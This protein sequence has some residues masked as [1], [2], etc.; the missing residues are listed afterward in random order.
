MAIY[1][2]GDLQGCFDE[3]RR[4]LDAIGFD[5]PGDTLWLTGDL[6]NRGPKS[7]ETL[8]FVKQLG[9]N[10]VTVLGNHDLHLLAIDAG[11]EKLRKKTDTLDE[12]LNAPDRE[13]L[14]NWLRFR[15]LVHF[16]EE[17]NTALLHAGL[18]PQWSVGDALRY[19]GEVESILR[20]GKESG[21]FEHM[22]G[23]EPTRWNDDLQG[24]DRLRFIVNTLTRMRYCTEEGEID[25]R[26]KGKPGTQPEG[27]L[28]WF[29]VSNRRSRGTRVVCGHWSTLG[30]KV[31]EEL[32]AID[33]GC[34]WGG[35]LTAIRLD[36]EISVT[37]VPC[38]MR[39][40][41][42]R[43]N[44]THSGE[45]EPSSAESTNVFCIW[46]FLRLDQG[47]QTV[48]ADFPPPVPP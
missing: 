44:P 33:T 45:I 2:I 35:Q 15:P 8:R 19:A 11:T 4:L 32:C 24:W 7:L 23:N 31:S 47:K 3:L 25:L 30:L 37:Q 12:L 14:L 18:P 46:Y 48:N 26:S 28:P 6:V 36:A 9:E 5:P 38:P 16:D 29:E 10:A 40:K 20:R 22:Y 17:L 27:F 34:L 1:A 13:D 39:C 42:S 21:F 43:I 41:P